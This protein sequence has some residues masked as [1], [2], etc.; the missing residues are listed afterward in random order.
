MS[1]MLG[2][3]AAAASS[4]SGRRAAAEAITIGGRTFKRCT[5]CGAFGVGVVKPSSWGLCEHC[6]RTGAAAGSNSAN[7]NVS[8]AGQKR[9]R[10]QYE[11]SNGASGE[12][13]LPPDFFDAG[14]RSTTD[15]TGYDEDDGAYAAGSDNNRAAAGGGG[16]EP[17]LS[18][19][20]IARMLAAAEAAEV[21]SLDAH[22]VKKLLLGFERKVTKNNLAR[23]KYPDQPAR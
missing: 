4:S 9:S 2:S 13:V 21:P 20:E 8:G 23:A 14:A 6:S 22:G 1:Q 17:E 10:E 5:S 16:G 7:A 12:S 3:S 19:E 18:E 11:Q 15:N